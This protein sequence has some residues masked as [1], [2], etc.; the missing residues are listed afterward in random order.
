VKEADGALLMPGSFPIHDLPDIGFDDA[1]PDEGDYTTVAGM[2][3]AALGHIPTTPGEVVTL[4]QFT[5]EVVEI[6]GRAITRVR[7]RALP[8]PDED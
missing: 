7:L 5:A 6:T 3:L 2:V 1:G 4:P 8:G